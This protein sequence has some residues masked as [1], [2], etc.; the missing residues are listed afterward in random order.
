EKLRDATIFEAQSFTSILLENQGDGSFTSKALPDYAQWSPINAIA[1][2]GDDHYLLAGNFLHSNIEMGWY[3][4]NYGQILS[5]DQNQEMS[6]SSLGDVRL[7]GE[8]RAVKP[9]LVNGQSCFLV[10]IN[11]GPLKLLK[12]E[13]VLQ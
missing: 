6:I 13:K 2:V 4:A 8:V 11:D 3:E 5:F 1:P 12:M 10:A 7:K 9:I